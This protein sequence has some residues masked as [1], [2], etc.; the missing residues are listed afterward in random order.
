M[1]VS[2][3]A[4]AP[5]HAL[6]LLV[7]RASWDD[8][9]ARDCGDMIARGMAWEEWLAR[10]EQNRLL[11]LAHRLL[12]G[13]ADVPAEVLASLRVAHVA[14]AAEA[15]RLTGEVRRLLAT[16]AEA[17]VHAVA[18]KGPALAVRAYGDVA[19]RTYSDLD[20]LIAPQDAAAAMRVLTE[21]GYESEHAFSAAQDRRFRA[22]DGDYPFH[23]P[24]TDTLVELHTQVS[25]ARFCMHLP[26]EELLSRARPVAVGGGTVPALDDAD[27]FLALCA[28]GAKHRWARLE[29]LAA[30]AALVRRVP[31]DPTPL[32]DRAREIGA[33]RT[34]LLALHLAHT[35]LE[36]PLAPSVLRSIQSDSVISTLADESRALWFAPASGETDTAANLRY[37]FR[38]RDGGKDRLR[39]AA[40][41][42]FTPSPEDWAWIRLPDGVS[43]M[44]RA[45]RPVRLAA[46]YAPGRP[47]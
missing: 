23:H 9:A 39:Y 11:P 38:L 44:Y 22:V 4:I 2:D 21:A 25:S 13:R 17:S 40:R 18:Y 14:N 8:D 35:A 19:L 5:E 29:W 24:G 36:L 46:R 47:R 3:R 10:A 45:L 30:V 15:L 12:A 42:L 6:L 33:G 34:V 1:T 31:L 16:L 27:L 32:A 41:W 20:L 28:H 43:W 26:S 7:A 37:N